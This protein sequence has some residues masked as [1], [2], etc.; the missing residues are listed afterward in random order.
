MRLCIFEGDFLDV[1][2]DCSDVSDENWEYHGGDCLKSYFKCNDEQ[3]CIEPKLV[4]DGH[5]FLS[6]F[7]GCKDS[8]DEAN[9]KDW[10]CLPGYWKCSD[11]QCLAEQFVCDGLLKTVYHPSAGCSDWSDEGRWC[12]NWTCPLDKWKCADGTRCIEAQYVCDGQG[13]ELI[14]AFGCLDGSDENNKLCGCDENEWPCLDGQGCISEISVCNGFPHCSDKSDE[15]SE[16]CLEWQC[17]SEMWKCADNLLCIGTY[18]V[19]DVSPDCS[20]GE[21]EL[22]CQNWTCVEGRWRCRNDPVCIDETALCDGQVHCRFG[23]DEDKQFCAAYECIYGGLKC[24][25]NTQCIYSNQIC[26]YRPDCQ[27]GSDELCTALCLEKPLLYPHEKSIVRK[28]QEDVNVCFPISKYCD[29]VPDCPFGTDETESNCE[30]NDWG[31]ESCIASGTNLCIV[32]EWASQSNTS[33]VHI[34]QCTETFQSN[35]VNDTW[36]R[37]QK[38]GTEIVLVLQICGALQL[39]D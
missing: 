27:D 37:E 19:C 39:N 31:L 34:P 7:P 20:G 23:S 8:S 15:L 36:I 26:N 12:K 22:G 16:I 21:D 28:C 11:G 38:S 18:E 29:G 9:C 2:L 17:P 13:F 10:E 6:P 35:G 25:D 32:P 4:C 24:A 14:S 33:K 5:G 1:V 3:K 30:C